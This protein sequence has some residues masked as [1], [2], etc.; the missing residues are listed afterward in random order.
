MLRVFEIFLLTAIVAA[1]MIAS[2]WIGEQC[3]EKS[4]RSNCEIQWRILCTA[5]QMIA[6]SVA[7]NPGLTVI[8]IAVK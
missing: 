5:L 1:N 2:K 6:G 4:Y 3:H 7:V 8:S